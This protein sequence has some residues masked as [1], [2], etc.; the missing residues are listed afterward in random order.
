[1]KPIKWRR[2]R[3]SRFYLECLKNGHRPC[4]YRASFNLIYIKCDECRKVWR[5]RVAIIEW[6]DFNEWYSMGK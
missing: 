2:T 4:V 3:I 5:V 6:C 1:M